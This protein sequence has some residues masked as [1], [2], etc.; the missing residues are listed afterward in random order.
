[1]NM[2]NMLDWVLLA[3]AFAM[4]AK[5]VLVPFVFSKF[6]KAGNIENMSQTDARTYIHKK[7]K[8]I[9]ETYI[10][11]LVT[12]VMLTSWL[13]FPKLEFITLPLG[14]LG[15]YIGSLV[16]TSFFAMIQ[17][18][19][20][21]YAVSQK[22]DTTDKISLI[23]IQKRTNEVLVKDIYTFLVLTVF[24]QA[25]IVGLIPFFQ[26]DNY[27]F[28]D[29]FTIAI[30]SISFINLMFISLT[31]RR[32]N[33]QK[34]Y[35]LNWLAF[36]FATVVRSIASAIMTYYSAYFEYSFDKDSII[37]AIVINSI[38]CGA[39]IVQICSLFLNLIQKKSVGAWYD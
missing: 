15:K 23:S 31:V 10:I 30:I 25:S 22:M 20:Y 1:M 34:K 28:I 8:N 33:K 3:I 9:N 39:A 26:V 14:N 5:I 16:E 6:A 35:F 36:T 32:H 38:V 13:L 12:Y 37:T 24:L 7:A 17:E 18:L 4:L 29:V 11:V 27:V 19:F 21:K 2:I